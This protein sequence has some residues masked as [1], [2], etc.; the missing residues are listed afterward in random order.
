MNKVPT[1]APYPR[2]YLE[3]L[4]LYNARYYWHTH[5]ELEALWKPLRGGPRDFYQGL[6]LAAAGFWHLDHS[7]RWWASRRLFSRAIDRL[8][9]YPSEQM[10]LD[11]RPIRNALGRAVES[12]DPDRSNPPGI[13]DIEGLRFE[14][15][16]EKFPG[17]RFPD[18]LPESGPRGP[19]PARRGF[20]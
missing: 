4:R 2:G 10:G 9:P 20:S 12:L 5:E 18:G 13:E 6:I 11:L 15:W 16:S 1:N 17:N 19:R 3:G 14:M 8:A 7:G